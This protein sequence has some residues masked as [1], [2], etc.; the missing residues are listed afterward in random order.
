MIGC[1]DNVFNDRNVNILCDKYKTFPFTYYWKSNKNQPFYHWNHSIV[2]SDVSNCENIENLLLEK[3]KDYPIE[4]SIWNNIKNKN[5]DCS[6]LRV[7]VNA[8]THG[9]DTSPHTDSI[10]KN[11]K[12]YIL[13]LN[14]EW[15]PMWCGETVI[16]NQAQTEIEKSYLP[17]FNRMITFP[18]DR[19]HAA[20]PI[21][22]SCN[23]LRTVLVFKISIENKYDKYLK[24]V[25]THKI[26]HSGRT[27]F[28][29]LYGTYNIL[30]NEG[31]PEHICLAG[32]FHSIY[33]TNTFL[34]ISETNRDIIRNI[35]GN[36]AEKLV[37]LFS[38]PDRKNNWQ[39]LNLMSDDINAL[40]IIELANITEQ[41][42][43][44]KK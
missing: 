25:N 6:L 24:S 13:Y 18:S 20:R 12:T 21:H 4:C 22:K 30:V 8:Y 28:E 11:E 34:H 5:P 43:Y 16:F 42:N 1:F 3:Q 2:E 44:I 41:K 40:K 9:N 36:D 26:A 35:I 29:H 19:L 15:N 10:R 27:L 14:R 38:N 31:Q 23:E 33:G 37:W 32:L 7:Y 17:K 39:N